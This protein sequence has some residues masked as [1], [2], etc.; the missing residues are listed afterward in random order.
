MEGII[1]AFA[2]N[3]KA[4]I[5]RREGFIPGVVYGKDVENSSVK[6]EKTKLINLLKEKGEKAKI[7]F[8]LDD[9]KKQGIIKEV[10]R[11]LATGEIVHID[12]QAVEGKESVKWTVPVIF[13]EKDLLNNRDLYLQ[14]Y[15][16]EVDVEGDSSKIP[17]NVEIAVNNMQ[18]GEEIKIKDLKLD[19]SIKLL[20]DPDTILAVITNA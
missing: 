5:A 4:R 8:Y 13:A 18:F 3:E 15:S 20:K 17:D 12:V 16:N 11:D 6:F 14:V 19:S 9:K 10:S 1:K 7:N 2:R